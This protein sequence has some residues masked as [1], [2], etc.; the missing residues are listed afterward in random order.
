MERRCLADF[1]NREDFRRLIVKTKNVLESK[2]VVEEETAYCARGF[3][4]TCFPINISSVK[5]VIIP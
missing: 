4:W 2:T 1:D 5:K 3:H